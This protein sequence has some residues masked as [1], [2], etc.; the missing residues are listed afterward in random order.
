MNHEVLEN[1]LMLINDI[2]KNYTPDIGSDIHK[3]T[4]ASLCEEFRA[5]LNELK[6]KLQGL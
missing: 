4:P 1:I 6:R 2:K 5:D 3:Q